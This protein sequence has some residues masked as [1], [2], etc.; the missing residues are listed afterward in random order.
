VGEHVV[1][2]RRNGNRWFLGALTDRTARDLS[3]KLDFLG[4][5][6]W[7]LKLWEDAPDS[8]P[9]VE[10]LVTKERFVRPADMLNLHLA[11]AG[12]AVAC[13]ERQSP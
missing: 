10:H 11:R 8:D 7:K 9:E 5:G 12:G 1:I 4:D 13:F 2:A 6:S 3:L